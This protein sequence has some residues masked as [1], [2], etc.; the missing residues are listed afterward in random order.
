MSKQT[1]ENN[2]QEEQYHQRNQQPQGQTTVTIQITPSCQLC[3]KNT[4]ST[5][6][7][8][9]CNHHQT[10]NKIQTNLIDRTAVEASYDN[11]QGH[12]NLPPPI[13]CQQHRLTNKTTIT[14]TNIH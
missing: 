14:I 13:N 11:Q 12:H 4:K 2:Q 3:Q 10:I 6:T 5:V 8:I 1:Q 9:T 7:T